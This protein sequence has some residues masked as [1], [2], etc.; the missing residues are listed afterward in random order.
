MNK[1]KTLYPNCSQS[2]CILFRV[3]VGSILLNG[4]VLSTCCLVN[5][6]KG[7]NKEGAL[8]GVKKETMQTKKMEM[9]YYVNFMVKHAPK[10]YISLSSGSRKNETEKKVLNKLEF[11]TVPSSHDV[12]ISH[13]RMQQ[14]LFSSCW[15][16]AGACQINGSQK[17][18][19]LSFCR[20]GL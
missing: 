16:F 11:F 5:C 18:K 6:K 10:L 4:N 13:R 7:K 1:R 8:R 9:E 17:Y 14:K 20:H 19:K 3:C 12:Y 2:L 15:C